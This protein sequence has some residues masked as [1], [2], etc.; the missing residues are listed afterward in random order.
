MI[1]TIEEYCRLKDE[2][3]EIYWRLKREGTAKYMLKSVE[4]NLKALEGE[5]RGFEYAFFL[6]EH[7]TFD[8][9]LKDYARVKEYGAASID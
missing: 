3:E 2:I 9:D 6:L 5:P 1:A 7:A 4:K 8:R